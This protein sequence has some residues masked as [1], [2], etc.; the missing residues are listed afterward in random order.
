MIVRD[1]IERVLSAYMNKFESKTAPSQYFHREMGTK[2]L[3][4]YRPTATKKEL[5]EGTGVTFPEFIRYIAESDFSLISNEHQSFNEHWEPINGLCNPCRVKYDYI[6]RMENLVEESNIILK[7]I[8]SEITY[9]AE[10]EIK[11]VGTRGKLQK[12]FDEIP[13]KHIRKL[14]KIYEIDNL[15]FNYSIEEAL[16]VRFN[17]E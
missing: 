6:A 7:K 8:N 1:P 13:I 12:Y 2:I 4:A 11:P 15:L 17:E 16:G 9:P 10:N 5:E 14:M 3:K